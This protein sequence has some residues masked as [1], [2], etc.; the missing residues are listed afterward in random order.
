MLL[1]R[2]LRSSGLQTLTYARPS[3]RVASH[4]VVRN[5]GKFFGERA[6]PRAFGRRT[7]A[8]AG[9]RE[10]TSPGLTWKIFTI[11]SRAL[12]RVASDGREVAG[13]PFSGRLHLA[14]RAAE[15]STA[16]PGPPRA[17]TLAPFSS[18]SKSSFICCV[19]SSELSFL[20]SVAQVYM[21]CGEIATLIPLD[22][23]PGLVGDGLE[24][25]RR[26][27]GRG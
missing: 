24:R 11:I 3:R 21:F 10:N 4:R 5:F 12:K 9:K 22:V 16:S 26:R 19:F 25:G 18:T 13:R 6:F 14:R 27:S 1:Q 8:V 7:T 23:E 2:Q 15:S 20:P 17:T